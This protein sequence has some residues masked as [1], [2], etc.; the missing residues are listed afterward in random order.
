MRNVADAAV[1]PRP[2]RIE[3]KTWTADDLRLFLETIH[4]DPPLVRATTRALRSPHDEA[5]ELVDRRRDRTRLARTGGDG[6]RDS[7]YGTPLLREQLPAFPCS[8]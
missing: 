4:E 1:V 8:E 3:M 2:K 5:N 7:R 6:E